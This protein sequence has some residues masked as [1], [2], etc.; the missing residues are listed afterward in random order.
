MLQWVP[1]WIPCRWP[2]WGGGLRVQPPRVGALSTWTSAVP[3]Q[4]GLVLRPAHS[5]HPPGPSLDLGGPCPVSTASW[6]Q[7]F[8]QQRSLLPCSLRCGH[9]ISEPPVL[10]VWALGRRHWLLCADT[11]APNGDTGATRCMWQDGAT[12]KSLP[13]LLFG[14]NAALVGIAGNGGAQTVL[15]G[16]PAAASQTP[17]RPFAVFPT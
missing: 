13:G 8:R 5:G 3:S 15:C 4:T 6:C 16:C 2:G 9:P 1:W 17:S 11:T 12:E 7:G 14:G 10:G